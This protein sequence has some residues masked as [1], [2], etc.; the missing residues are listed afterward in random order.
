MEVTLTDE[1]R[2]VFL[3][4]YRWLTVI[5]LVLKRHFEALMFNLNS[6]RCITVLVLNSIL[7]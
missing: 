7:T 3:K 4:P 2:L 5:I 1:S 6:D